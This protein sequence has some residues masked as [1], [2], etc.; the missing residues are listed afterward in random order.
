MLFPS[1]ASVALNTVGFQFF[2]SCCSRSG[3]TSSVS[4]MSLSIL[5]QLH[6]ELIK[7][8]EKKFEESLLSILS[9]LHRTIDS[10]GPPSRY[11]CL[12]ILSQL[13]LSLKEVY[14]VNH[15]Y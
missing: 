7:K 2:P 5:S 8:E 10:S 13:H 12:S 15:L 3:T 14:V 4:S 9:Q 1:A 6:H 11:R